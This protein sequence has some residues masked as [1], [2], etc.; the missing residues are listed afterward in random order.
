MSKESDWPFD[1]IRTLP[2]WIQV[3]I[4]P[5]TFVAILIWSVVALPY[6]VCMV[7]IFWLGASIRE[8]KFRRAMSKRGRLLLAKQVSDRL[9][10]NDG[11]LIA[12]E[13]I[14][15]TGWFLPSHLISLAPSCVLLP[16][17]EYLA[18]LKS[19][20]EFRSRHWITPEILAWGD[21]LRAVGLSEVSYVPSLVGI[22]FAARSFVIPVEINRNLFVYWENETGVKR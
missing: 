21:Q 7:A 4:W 12:G 10:R 2:G 22:D 18:R 16:L 11:W 20:H 15:A 17:T 1:R 9:E 6:F 19:G 5:P 14:V 3:V 8:S 13:D